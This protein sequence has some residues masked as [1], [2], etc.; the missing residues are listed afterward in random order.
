M[1]KLAFETYRMAILEVGTEFAHRWMTDRIDGEGDDPDE[2]EQGIEHEGNQE[3]VIDDYDLRLALL[4]EAAH[5]HDER[6]KHFAA[7]NASQRTSGHHAKWWMSHTLHDGRVSAL[8]QWVSREWYFVW[9]IRRR[10]DRVVFG[11][12]LR[13]GTLSKHIFGSGIQAR[14]YH[15]KMASEAIDRIKGIV[16]QRSALPVESTA[17]HRQIEIAQLEP[18]MQEA[19]VLRDVIMASEA[20]VHCV[21]TLNTQSPRHGRSRT[22]RTVRG[23]RLG[24]LESS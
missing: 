12:H 4:S 21:S 10:V 6:R 5:N 2:A 19:I 14:S 1:E 3:A 13:S 15:R 22:P 23:A 16:A 20:E 17:R 11:S 7:F 18:F 24:P 8:D 9:V